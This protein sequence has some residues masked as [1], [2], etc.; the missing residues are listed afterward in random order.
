MKKLCPVKKTLLPFDSVVVG[1]TGLSAAASVSTKQAQGRPIIKAARIN[2]V[3]FIVFIY[4][5]RQGQGL[6]FSW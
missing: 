6:S 5:P 3:R 4:A 2:V 1:A